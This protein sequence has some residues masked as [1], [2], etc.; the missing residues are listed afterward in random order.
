MQGVDTFEVQMVLMLV[1]LRSL[2]KKSLYL[3]QQY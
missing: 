3:L 1:T 2:R